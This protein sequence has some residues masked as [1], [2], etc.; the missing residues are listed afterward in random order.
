MTAV[1]SPPSTLH[2]RISNVVHYVLIAVCLYTLI[3]AIHVLSSALAFTEIPDILMEALSNPLFAIAAGM[4]I[5]VLLQSSSASTAIIIALSAADTIS[6][7]TAVFLVMGANIGTT[8]TNS[9][10][11]LGY[12]RQSNMFAKTFAAGTVHDF[13]NIFAVLFFGILE[14]TTGFLSQFAQWCATLFYDAEANN[15]ATQSFMQFS[16]WVAGIFKIPVSLLTSWNVPNLVLLVIAIGMILGS[17]AGL[18]KVLKALY[19]ARHTVDSDVVLPPVESSR[20]GDIKG[21]VSGAVTTAVVQS[22]SVTTSAAVV[23]VGTGRYTTKDIYPFIAGANIGTTMTALLVALMTTS[24]AAL[25]VAFAHFWFN[26]L[27]VLVLFGIPK[28]GNIPVLCADIMYRIVSK[29]R[30]YAVAYLGVFLLIPT[31]IILVFSGMI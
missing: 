10:V 31:L 28:L 18:S 27:A 16:T 29:S 14:Y 26:V 3:A 5:T 9:A 20:L 2:S 6:I 21:I 7:S 23:G 30:W 13:L 24:E 8:I 25:T 15:I 12:I 17:I 22:S 4:I 1:Q 19:A 11:A